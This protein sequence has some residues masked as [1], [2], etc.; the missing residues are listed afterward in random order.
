[1]QHIIKHVQDVLA[2]QIPLPF[3]VY[4]S[5]SDQNISNVP[6]VKPVIIFVLSG[7]KY[8]GPTSDSICHA[9]DFVFLSNHPGIDMRNISKDEGYFALLI[10][11]ELSDFDGL[12]KPEH[13]GDTRYFIEPSKP[14]LNRLLEQFVTW[15]ATAPEAIWPLRRKE[16]LHHLYHM[17]YTQV[18]EMAIPPSLSLK[19]HELFKTHIS[20]DLSSDDICKRLA[21]SE[22]TLRRKLKAEHTSLQNIRDDTK[23]GH[24][25]HLL[26]STTL[27]IGHIAVECGYTSQS[28]FTERF[29]QRFGLTPSELRK[30]R[31]TE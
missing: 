20:E 12:P 19:L 2:Q 13:K 28:R 9:G 25:L 31:M 7:Q 23:L 15:S 14:D 1:M 6:I 5:V 29:K 8:L 26:Q 30:T 27:P 24:G 10:E 21:M 18:L 16:I 22:S 3:A 17:G 11:F 4:T